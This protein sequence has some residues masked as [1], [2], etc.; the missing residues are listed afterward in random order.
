MS[1]PAEI[2]YALYKLLYLATLPAPLPQS[3]RGRT[4]RFG[5]APLVF[6]VS[7]HLARA[8]L[9]HYVALQF[10]DLES[11]L[12]DVHFPFHV[13]LYKVVMIRTVYM[14]LISLLQTR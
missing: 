7:Y 4:L 3:R 10:L 8:A 2:I 5:A 12:L 6:I 9:S 11:R 14:R 13:S 1:Q